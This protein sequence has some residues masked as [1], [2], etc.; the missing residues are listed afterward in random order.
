MNNVGLCLFTY[1]Q[2]SC[3]YLSLGHIHGSIL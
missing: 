3:R 2:G 1:D